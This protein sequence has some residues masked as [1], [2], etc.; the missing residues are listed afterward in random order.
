MKSM[1]L[2][3][4]CML[5]GDNRNYCTALFTLDVGAI[6][7]DKH[8]LDGATEVKRSKEQKQVGGAGFS[9]LSKLY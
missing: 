6:L 2:I 8:G 3:S 5:V 1:P 7:R 9:K 4:Q